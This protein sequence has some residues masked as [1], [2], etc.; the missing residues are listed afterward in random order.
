VAPVGPVEPV[1]P[2]GPVE[3]VAPVGPVGPVAP[4][5]PTNP[6]LGPVHTPD[7]FMTGVVFTVNPFLTTK[8]ELVPKVHS[9]LVIVVIIFY[10]CWVMF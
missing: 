5:A 7:E 6:V 4:V 10:L 3:P 8:L 2:V 9:P 1:D